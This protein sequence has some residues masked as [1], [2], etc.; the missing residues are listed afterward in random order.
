[1]PGEHPPIRV[2]V[3]APMAAI[4][5]TAILCATGTWLALVLTHTVRPESGWT[6]LSHVAA[7]FGGGA[8]PLT[9]YWR[10][11]RLELELESDPPKGGT[12]AP[13]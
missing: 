12:D 5:C 9:S 2:R 6:L 1:M 11:K 3:N 13:S 4:A 8:L 7:F 10:E